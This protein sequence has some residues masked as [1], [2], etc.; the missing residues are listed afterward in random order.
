[1]AT[2]LESLDDEDAAHGPD[3][4]QGLNES[5]WRRMQRRTYQPRKGLVPGGMGITASQAPVEYQQWREACELPP[6]AWL[7]HTH[8]PQRKEI[9]K[10]KTDL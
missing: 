9:K 6:L 1:M 4:K 5:W 7:V 3:I 10:P 2:Q 8:H